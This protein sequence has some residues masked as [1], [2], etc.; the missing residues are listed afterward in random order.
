MRSG[1]EQ[2]QIIAACNLAPIRS[3]Q[4]D[5]CESISAK[6]N[7]SAFGQS[8]APAGCCWHSAAG[9]RRRAMHS[10]KLDSSGFSVECLPSSYFLVVIEDRA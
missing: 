3:Q 1:E 4:R 5:R 10:R 8:K 2:P 7:L 9:L 6:G